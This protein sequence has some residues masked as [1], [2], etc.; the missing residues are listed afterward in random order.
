MPP[1]PAP[2]HGHGSTITF[3]TTALVAR[4]QKFSIS[5]DGRSSINTTYYGSG[6]YAEY[7]PSAVWD[8]GTLTVNGQYGPDMAA[9]LWDLK[10]ANANQLITVLLADG[11]GVRGQGHA[12]KV[13]IDYG[14]FENLATFTITIKWSG[15]LVRL[16]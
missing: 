1:V 13:D 14:D 16:P 3:A 11:T 12:Q 2:T 15:E 8:A 5:E 7:I 4:F 9:K 6:G 10:H